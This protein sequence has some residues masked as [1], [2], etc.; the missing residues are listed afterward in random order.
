MAAYQSIRFKA[1]KMD[2]NHSSLERRALL[3][4]IVHEYEVIKYSV[5]KLFNSFYSNFF[6]NI[7][8]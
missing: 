7:D 1:R 8:K 2:D 4:L 5:N 3:L 6:E